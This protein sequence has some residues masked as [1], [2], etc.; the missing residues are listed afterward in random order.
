[1]KYLNALLLVF[2][3][4]AGIQAC[5]QQATPE[6]VAQ[7]FWNAVVSNDKDGMQKYVAK[8]SLENPSLLDN[9]DKMLSTVEIGQALIK[10]GKATIETVLI[11]HENDKETRLPITTSLSLENDQWKVNGQ[12]SINALVA[13]S[14]NL[15]MSDMTKDL[16]ALGQQ[17]ND[18][19]STGLQEFL[20]AF[21][22]EVPTLKQ[23]LD[24]FSDK[25]K[26]QE[27]GQKM[28]TLF[29]QG[30][31]NVLQEFNKGL[32]ELSQELD[33]T[34]AKPAGSQPAAPA[35]EKI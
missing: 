5:A 13:T 27:I 2:L 24:K 7:S 9:T 22:R 4:I 17:L 12:E 21:N 10:D 29:S 1:M 25:E 33:K 16:S 31:N 11:N 3:A 32:D 8:G 26:A 19:I 35:G 6:E 15:M 18:S 14:M 34:E 23:E 28:G 30:L 20:S